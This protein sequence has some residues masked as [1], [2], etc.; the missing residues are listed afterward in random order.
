MAKLPF[1]K[2]R[3]RMNIAG[4]AQK[5]LALWM[6]I[7]RFRFSSFDVLE[8]R[9]FAEVIELTTWGHSHRLLDPGQSPPKPPTLLTPRITG[10]FISSLHGAI[11][12]R[13]SCLA[14]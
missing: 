12:R 3:W 5:F 7:R 13:S 4:M 10:D 8:E 9:P 6:M 14:L 1:D 11:A 2:L